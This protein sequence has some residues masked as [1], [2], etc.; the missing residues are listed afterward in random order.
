MVPYQHPG[1]VEFSFRCSI[2]WRIPPNLRVWTFCHVS[3]CG[4][5]LLTS[6]FRRNNNFHDQIGSASNRFTAVEKTIKIN[7]Y[8]Y[9]MCFV[10]IIAIVLL[11]WF[12][13]VYVDC[14]LWYFHSSIHIDC[15]PFISFQHIWFVDLMLKSKTKRHHS[16]VSPRHRNCNAFHSSFRLNIDFLVPS[17]HLLRSSLSLALSLSPSPSAFLIL[18]FVLFSG[19]RHLHDIKTN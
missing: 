1:R 10:W 12:E 5:L 15:Y 9:Y 3:D 8:V 17:S 16:I 4:L 18:S 6:S 14:F 19:C 7:A 13:C 11:K 2:F